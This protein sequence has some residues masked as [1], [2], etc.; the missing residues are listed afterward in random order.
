MSGHTPGPWLIGEQNGHCG[1][2]IDETSEDGA[3]VATVYLG[4]VTSAARWGEEHFA[5]PENAEAMANARLIA[6]APD[7]LAALQTFVDLFG[8][9]DAYQGDP[10]G[11]ACVR[12]ARAA[13]AKAT[14]KEG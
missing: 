14:G 13:I 8:R 2:S 1:V 6:A 3:R 12:S 5:F 10:A 9:E 4:I 7:M 11:L